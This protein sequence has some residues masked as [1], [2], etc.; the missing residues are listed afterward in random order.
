MIKRHYSSVLIMH[1]YAI[2]SFIVDKCECNLK[3]VTKCFFFWVRG[4]I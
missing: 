1:Q 2:A 3:R 4:Q